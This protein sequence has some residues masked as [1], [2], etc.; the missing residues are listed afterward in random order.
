MVRAAS[1]VRAATAVLPAVRMVA[2]LAADN[3]A[4]EVGAAK[5][6]GTEA[7]VAREAAVMAPAAM[8][9]EAGATLVR[10]SRPL[11]AH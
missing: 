3:L 5:A 4:R 8:A 6:L 2:G 10:R 11:S 9:R 7:V 1:E